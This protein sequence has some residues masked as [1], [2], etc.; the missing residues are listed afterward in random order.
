MILPHPISL[1]S[2]VKSRTY[3]YLKLYLQC[4]YIV[5]LKGRKYITIITA[6]Y[7]NPG[8]V[9]YKLYI[10]ILICHPPLHPEILPQPIKK[11]MVS[12]EHCLLSSR[13]ENERALAHSEN[14]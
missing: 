4:F 13:V 5:S 7:S 6:D 10:Q 2:A 8:T 14:N 3:N 11:S 9:S 1:V 12:I